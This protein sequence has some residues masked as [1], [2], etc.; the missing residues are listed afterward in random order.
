[1][2]SYSFL[3]I[4]FIVI[5]TFIISFQCSNSSKS[6]NPF[7]NSN[8]LSDLIISSGTLSPSFHPDSLT[9]QA[10]VLSDT[11]SVTPSVL[12]TTVSIAVNN[13]TVLSSQSS[14]PISL[15]LGPNTIT[16][17]VTSSDGVMST[18]YTI[19]VNRTINT[20]ATLSGLFI[21]HG[22]LT[23]SFDSTIIQYS[24]YLK[25]RYSKLVCIPRTV[26][27]FSIVRINDSIVLSDS[28]SD[29]IEINQGVDTVVI[30]VTAQDTIIKKYYNIFVNRNCNIAGS[31]EINQSYTSGIF[32]GISSI[33][34]WIIFQDSLDCLTVPLR[35]ESGLI[36]STSTISGNNVQLVLTM[37]YQ[38][39]HYVNILS[40]V[41]TD[42][43]VMGNLISNNDT[44][45]VF[46]M[47]KQSDCDS[48]FSQSLLQVNGYSFDG[49]M[50]DWA[51]TPVL[52][53]DG[54]GDLENN[55]MSSLDI[56]IFKMSTNISK[57]TLFLFTQ[58]VDTLDTVNYL[59]FNFMEF[60][61]LTGTSIGDNFIS[62]STDD[63]GINWR[64]VSEAGENTYTQYLLYPPHNYK[65][66]EFGIPLNHIG[67]N[68]GVI[69]TT[70][71][72]L[73]EIK[74]SSN[75]SKNIVY[76]KALFWGII[77][78]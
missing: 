46:F 33:S 70:K 31:W 61:S 65:C 53:F 12:D 19:L 49:S 23:P 52:I 62:L 64:I 68:S 16:I 25:N 21:S 78:F 51:S 42:T 11:I 55:G 59:T 28:S 63:G 3:N 14:Q 44:C 35:V 32:K 37:D 76:D 74:S 60:D 5:T 1:M 58:F 8:K 9:Y 75:Y 22:T 38:S 73:V 2:H 57:D 29:S 26:D 50:A 24:L 77:K 41:A 71:N 27:P 34:H 10:V 56:Y 39:N 18:S 69:D 47:K 48:V 20:N 40:G 17:T 7:L 15:N 66:I 45:G 6:F 4:F 67:N 36:C 43:G 30:Q 13:S 54:S 72:Y